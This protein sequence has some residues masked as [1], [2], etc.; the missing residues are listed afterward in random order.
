MLGK[1]SVLLVLCQIVAFAYGKC[2]SAIVRFG[3][4]TAIRMGKKISWQNF[5]IDPWMNENI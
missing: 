4:E 1:L 5:I 3:T 2:T